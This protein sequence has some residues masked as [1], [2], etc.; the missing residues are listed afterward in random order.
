MTSSLSFS[1]TEVYNFFKKFKMYQTEHN[2]SLTLDLTRYD[3]IMTLEY[4]MCRFSDRKVIGNLFKL[5]YKS[6]CIDYVV[7][8][9]CFISRIPNYIG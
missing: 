2:T 6:C 7:G 3:L 5:Y 8:R 4:L 9:M 1:C